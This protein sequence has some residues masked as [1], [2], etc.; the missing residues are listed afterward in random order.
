MKQSTLIVYVYEIRKVYLVARR[1]PAQAACTAKELREILGI[2][3][4]FPYEKLSSPLI[5]RRCCYINIIWS[6]M[7]QYCDEISLESTSSLFSSSYTCLKAW[8]IFRYEESTHQDS[9]SW[10]NYI[11]FWWGT[12]YYAF[13]SETTAMNLLIVLLLCYLN[14]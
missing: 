8:E 12:Y 5:C 2:I 10:P 1:G 4:T 11:S 9:A 6:V 13:D 3:S 14:I 7:I